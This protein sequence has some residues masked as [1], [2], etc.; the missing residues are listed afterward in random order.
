MRLIYIFFL[1]LFLSFSLNAQTLKGKVYDSIST[2]KN[3]KIY[4]ETQHS[5]TVTDDDGNFSLIAKVNDTLL[6]ESVFYYPKAVVL[7]QIH[8]DDVAIFEIRKIINALDEVEVMA[9]P[10]QPVFELETYNKELQDLIAE[11]IKNHPEKYK[12]ELDYSYGINIGA[13][14]GLLAKLVKRKEPKYRAPVY[15]AITYKQMDSLFSKSYFFDEQL[16]TSN[17]Q[18]PKDKAHLF[19]DFCEAK[20]MS[21]ELLKEENKMQFLEELVLNSQLF[22]A[23]LEE[24]GEKK[25]IKD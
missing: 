16:L 17:L 3:I 4:N 15:Q 7:K 19:Y 2:V 5:V 6:F 8:F 23:L 14:I 22:I 25:T 11:D 10:E 18:I 24:Y 20:Y 1:F 21:S 13:V 12:P 9:D